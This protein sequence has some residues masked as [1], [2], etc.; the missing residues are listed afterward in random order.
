MRRGIL[1][2]GVLLVASVAVLLSLATRLTPYVRDRVV[3]ALNDRFDS[4]VELQSLQVSI[5]PRPEVT[6]GGLIVR[7]KGRRDVPPLIS[8]KAFSAGAG[9]FGLIGKPLRLRTVDLDGLEIRI[10]PGGLNSDRDVQPEPSRRTE[11]DAGLGTPPPP[12]PPAETPAAR[13]AGPTP[14]LIDTIRSTSARLEITSKEPGKLPRLFEIHDLVMRDFGFDRA[15][16]FQASLTNPKPRGRI[17]TK[18]QFGPWRKED[19][20]LTPLQGEYAFK[21]ADLNT[22]NGIG[23]LLSSV[24]QYSGVLDR[25]DVQGE[26]DTPD[27]VVD[28]SGQPV[29]L[30][31]RFT[32]V[33]DGTNG[34]TWLVPVEAVLGSSTI[35]TRGAVVRTEDVKGRKVSLDVSIEKAQIEDLLKLAVKSPKP[36]LTGAVKLSTKFLLPA[37]ERDV[38]QRLELDGAFTI[39]QARFT[40]LDVQKRIDTLSRRGRGDTDDADGES[41]VSNLGG[42]FVM[43]DGTIRFSDLVFA[44]PGAVVQLA[45]SYNLRGEILD[46]AG[47]LLLDATLAETTSGF[48]AELGRMAQPLFR[49]P[50]G[51]SKLPIK[52]SGPR[53]KPSFGLDTKRALTPG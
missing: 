49:R 14:I 41:V 45:G 10:P 48:K 29:H 39:D 47:H 40:S 35:L 12:R 16:S 50:G 1:I 17:E 28:V 33:V 5:F 15:A 20:R 26:T 23:G 3:Q 38:A 11:P 53:A 19:P 9:V 42:R 34:N 4:D 2:V 18:G 8:I 30:R 52:I 21:Q 27:F 22:I 32:A 13:E 44:V 25:I 51:G 36:P 31:T 7:H 37:G 43:K 46:F 6:G 24:G